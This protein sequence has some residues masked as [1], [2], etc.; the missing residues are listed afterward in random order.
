MLKTACLKNST[1]SHA[2]VF[3]QLSKNSRESFPLTNFYSTYGSS[4]FIKEQCGGRN[5]F[6]LSLKLKPEE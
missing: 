2:T 5:A 6:F 3:L 1:F 4:A